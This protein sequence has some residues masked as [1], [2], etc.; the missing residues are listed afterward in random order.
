MLYKGEFTSVDGRDYT[1]EI[2]TPVGNGTKALRLSGTPFVSSVEEGDGGLYA[3]IR[4]GGATV[5]ILVD[6]PLFD[7][8]SG[9]AQGVEV[10]LKE[11]DT[12]VWTGFVSP[13]MYDQSFDEELEELQLDCVDG[14]AVLKDIPFR[15]VEGAED[16]TTFQDIL[17]RVLSSAGCITGLYVSNNVQMRLEDK[18]PVLDVM[19][20]S[21]SNFFEDKS[22]MAQTDDDVAWSCYKVLEEI[23]RFLGFTVVC[24]GDRV[25][26]VDYDSIRKGEAS[27]YYYSLL[28]GK[29]VYR[30]PA[31][32]RQDYH[33]EGE[34]YGASGTSISLSPIYNKVS[35]VDSFHTYDNVFPAF[36]DI[37]QETNVTAPDDPELIARSLQRLTGGG[38]IGDG[39]W[40][41]DEMFAADN[42]DQS[43][44]GIYRPGF[45]CGD[46]FRASDEDG[47][48]ENFV[49]VVSDTADGQTFVSFYKFYDSPIFTFRK[50]RKHPLRERQ[51]TNQTWQPGNVRFSGMWETNGAFYMRVAH[52]AAG[53]KF[54]LFMVNT[55]EKGR[56]NIHN[57]DPEKFY[58]LPQAERLAMW[59]DALSDSEGEMDLKPIIYMQNANP[60]R[61]GPGDGENFGYKSENEQAKGYPFITLKDSFKSSIFGGEGRFL[62]IKGTFSYHDFPY[63]PYPWK[64][65]FDKDYIDP[66]NGL[67]YGPYEDEKGEEQKGMEDYSKHSD[68]GFLWFRLKWGN[69]WWNG[70]EW[71]A[72]ECWFKIYFW[73]KD[74]GDDKEA[75]GHDSRQILRG[76]TNKNQ[77]AKYDFLHND[78]TALTFGKDGYIVP[79][80]KDGSLEGTPEIAIATRDM[81]GS[82]RGIVNENPSSYTRDKNPYSFVFSNCVF[83]E[84]LQITAEVDPGLLN[85]KDVDSDTVYT[86]V[87]SNGSVSKMSDISFRVCTDDGKKLSYSSVA[88][89]DEEGALRFVKNLYNLA[90]YEKE[91][92][93]R[94]ADWEDSR[95]RQEEHCVF[96]NA[97]QYSSPRLSLNCTLHNTDYK[98]YGRFTDETLSE[99]IY[100]PLGMEID[101]KYN[102]CTLKLLEKA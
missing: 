27:Y 38:K 30:T 52:F 99:R 34:S 9:Q 67:H 31:S 25:Y 7:L 101:Y 28:Q 20:I 93:T 51:D 91:R 81:Y 56:W 8:Y 54:H 17:G 41:S 98:M 71:Q 88:Y 100:V 24:H 87:I 2:Y 63:T 89:Y 74:G 32:L 39:P 47:I 79:A 1:I 4:C 59:L 86:N 58:A 42:R 62:R 18:A 15:K 36:G 97:I 46:V 29:L 49:L 11:G 19:R 55:L 22:D 72:T 50:Y 84:D 65:P 94:G 37:S 82:Y 10:S 85:D 6:E 40:M 76:Y 44:L 48:P 60:Y 95:L 69:R 68:Q 33:I 23:C 66:I 12:I 3:P 73:N 70:E 64:M 5:G 96:K 43:P 21:Q 75:A 90:L 61:I 83:I 14:I 35:V 53:N 13:T 92:A 16:I 102:L 45:R 80:P 57:P 77:E 78:A 26:M